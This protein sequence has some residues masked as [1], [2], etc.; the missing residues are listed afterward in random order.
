MPIQRKVQQTPSLLDD[1]DLGDYVKSCLR[2][3]SVG[4]HN[5]QFYVTKA[6]NDY[7]DSYL[8]NDGVWRK[9]TTNGQNQKSGFFDTTEEAERALLRYVIAELA[10]NIP[11]C[12]CLIM[13]GCTC[14]VMKLERLAKKYT[15]P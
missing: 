14:G 12:K 7:D 6:G 2:R 9:G 10:K 8:H 5:K 13:A 3:F 15:S 1:D 4:E 11:Q